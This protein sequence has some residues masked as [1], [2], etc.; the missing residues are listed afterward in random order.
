M[1]KN[2][3]SVDR[4]LRIILG[5]VVLAIGFYFQSWWGLIG[6][7]PLTTAFMNWCPAY[8]PFGLSTC[9]TKSVNDTP[10]K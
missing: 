1:K 9:K 2:V 10:G 3:G 7:V 4:T 6:L 5:L 8:V